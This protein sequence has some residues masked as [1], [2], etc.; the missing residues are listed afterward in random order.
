MDN[1]NWQH[2]SFVDGS[3]PYICKT[4][5]EFNRIKKKYRL[6]EIQKNFWLA[7]TQNKFT[8]FS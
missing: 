6:V 7:K 4:E 2:I 5:E 8:E 3:N 1:F